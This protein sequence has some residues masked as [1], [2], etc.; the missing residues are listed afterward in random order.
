MNTKTA[1]DREIDR[2]MIKPGME[3]KGKD[4][5]TYNQI[6]EQ[7]RSERE[8]LFCDGIYYEYQDGVYTSVKEDYIRKII[9]DNLGDKFSVHASSEVL[10]SLR[11]EIAINDSEELNNTD[12]VNLKNGMLDLGT[13]TLLPHSPQYKSTIQLPVEYNPD[14][15]CHKWQRTLH[16]IFIDDPVKTDILQ[17]FFGLCL[18]RE[19][20]HAKAL[21][22]IGE[23]ANGKSTILH[24]LEQVLSKRNYASIP[25]EQFNNTHYTANLYNKL[26]NISIETN[27]KSSV[28]DS[29]MK[30]V[31]S[32]DTITADF[33][34][35]PPF[36]FN[37]CCKLIFALNNMPRVDD[38]TDSFFRRLII[39]RFN[40]QFGEEEQ[41]K[42]LNRTVT[43]H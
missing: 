9:K 39:V 22:L 43:G 4:S 40:R 21:F 20:R 24:V 1:L 18:T 35:L 23:G 29:L 38:K 12:L 5:F 16:E 33:K 30:A 37:P 3:D 14:A 2:I 26:A 34:Y 31:V 41:N 13:L 27:A 25:L 42:N 36:Q 7:I 32:G 8:L 6:A 15:C 17:E 19:T 10:L 28:Y 11:V